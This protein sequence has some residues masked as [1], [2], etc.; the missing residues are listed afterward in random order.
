MSHWSDTARRV[1]QEV[2]RGLPETATLE[3]RTKAVDA[4]YPFGLRQYWPYKAWLKARREYL[5]RYGYQSKGKPI[6]PLYESP[7]ERMKRRSLAILK[8]G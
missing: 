2:H 5:H 6:L 7:M 1:I 4:A 8:E 3:E